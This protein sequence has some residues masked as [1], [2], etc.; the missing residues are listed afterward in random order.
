MDVAVLHKCGQP[1]LRSV[2]TSL[3]G[4]G[5]LERVRATSLALLGATAAVGL[6]I[7]A[8]ALNQSWPLI[9]GSSIPVVPP[10]QQAVGNATVAARGVSRTG[11]AKTASQHRSARTADNDVGHGGGVAPG[12]PTTRSDFVVSPSTPA[13]PEADG[14]PGRPKNNPAPSSPKPEGAS[15][16][17]VPA[18]A[19]APAT[20]PSPPASVAEP[21][22]PPA[23]TAEVPDEEVESFVPPWSHGKG[24]A[25]GRADDD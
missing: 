4:H 6:A 25:Y 23:T 15:Q 24:H 14:S 12:A 22:P 21:A 5:L 17:P 16:P 11:V 10:R 9:A 13:K 18:A 19:P 8:L 3:L 1:L 20:P 2:G 7:V